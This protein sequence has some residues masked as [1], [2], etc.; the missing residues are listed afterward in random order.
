MINEQDLN[1]SY[2]AVRGY[3]EAQCK[4][5]PTEDFQVQAADF[6]SPPKWHLAHT[7]WFF[8]QFVLRPFTNDYQPLD[9]QFN[10]LFNSYYE[11]VGERH[12]RPKRGLVTRPTVEDVYR[13]RD[14]VDAA[15]H[16]FLERD[17]DTQATALVVLGLHHEQQH[18]ELFYTDLKYNLGTQPTQPRYAGELDEAAYSEQDD[19]ISID[20]GVV[21]IGYTG[22]GFHFDNEGPRHKQ[23]VHATKLRTSLVTNQEYLAFVEDG[24]YQDHRLWHSDGWSW[25]QDNNINAPLYWQKREDGWHEYTLAGAKPLDL[26]ATVAHVSFYEATAFAQWA[27]YRLP[28][29]IQREV[30]AP[31]LGNAGRWEWTNSAYLPYPGY[32]APSGAVGEYNG[33]FMV[34]QMV[35]RGAS[36]ATSPGHSRPTYRNFFYPDQRWQYTGIRLAT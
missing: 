10:Y 9:T 13:Y 24:G 6:A 4:N 2:K 18:Q 35:L 32:C 31:R 26:N 28:T 33:K 19:W 11:G 12:A 34:N 30:A 3:S 8:E 27:G 14:H 25:V 15:M 7:T 36:V 5:L 20:E 23:Y 22:T 1:A 16:A 17:P 29:E 21:E